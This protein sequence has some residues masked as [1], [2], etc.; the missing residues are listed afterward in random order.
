MAVSLCFSSGFQKTIIICIS[1]ICV[2]MISTV[3]ALYCDR[4]YILFIN[5]LAGLARFERLVD[6]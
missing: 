4:E 2:Q 5:L 6:F 3:V 1:A